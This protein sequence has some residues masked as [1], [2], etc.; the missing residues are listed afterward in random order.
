MRFKRALSTLGQRPF[1]IAIAA[2]LFITG[3]NDLVLTRYP[4][5]VGM[6][7]DSR[8]LDIYGLFLILGSAFFIYAIF[9]SD[10][11]WSDRLERASLTVLVGALSAFS[12]LLAYGITVFG[13]EGLQ[14]SLSWILVLAAASLARVIY[15]GKKIKCPGCHSG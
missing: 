9:S 11:V 5:E 7:V 1:D 8:V 3:V 15:L 14:E 10:K 13:A 2:I 6:F 4:P 12:V